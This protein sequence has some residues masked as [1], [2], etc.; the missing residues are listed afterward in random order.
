MSERDYRS[1]FKTSAEVLKNLLSGPEGQAKATGH[2]ADQFLR[3][4]L[5]M[6][7]QDIVGQTTAQCCEP[8]AYHQGTLWLWVKNATWLTQLNFMSETIKNTINQKFAAGMVREI[9]LTMDRKNVPRANDQEFKNNLEKFL[10][11]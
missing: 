8:V 2:M 5:W 11:K 10:K 6:S 3:W 7:W 4:K 1:K 9:R